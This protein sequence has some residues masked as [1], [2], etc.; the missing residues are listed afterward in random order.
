MSQA[1]TVGK[2]IASNNEAGIE[3]VEIG[4]KIWTTRNYVF[5]SLPEAFIGK[6]F[7]KA[8]YGVSGQTVDVTVQKP[9]YIYVLTNAYKTNNSQ[10]ETLDGLNYTKLDMANW[11]FC[12][13]PENTSYIWVYE[14]YVEAGEK[15]QLGQWSVVI[16]SE[17]KLNLDSDTYKVSDTDMA[18]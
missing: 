3:F 12:D 15:L 16:A 5:T 14:K 6:E 11:K 1:K 2:M 17:E 18:V 9:G 7:V 10:A 13:F 8:S 4:K